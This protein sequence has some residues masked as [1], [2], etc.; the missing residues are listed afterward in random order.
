L[1]GL[2]L[3]VAALAFLGLLN[4]GTKLWFTLPRNPDWS[5]LATRRCLRQ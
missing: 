3:A 5:W 4:G 1:F 2:V